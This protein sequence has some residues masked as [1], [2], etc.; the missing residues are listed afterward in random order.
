MTVRAVLF[1]LGDTLLYQARRPK[2]EDFHERVAE[3]VNPLL[4][5]WGVDERFD[6]KS[7]VRSLYQGIEATESEQHEPGYQ[8]DVPAIARRAL[9]EH[10]VEASPDQAKDLWSATYLG[11]EAWGY[12]LYPDTLDT[13]RRLRSMGIPTGLVSNTWSGSDVHL[14]DLVSLGISKSL[15]HV[16]VFSAD[17]R[18]AK[19][20][21]EP[22]RRALEG[23]AVQP[24]D[25]AFVGDN[26][27]ADI[28]GAKALGM[29]T[30]WKLNGRQDAPPAEEADHRI[31]ELREIFT[32]GVLP[33]TPARPA[34][35]SAAI[36]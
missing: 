11:F 13:L 27:K 23:L 15:M 18:R 29:T 33:E 12:E 31:H 5:S 24:D 36:D 10:G 16:F 14:P 30:I 3:R 9:A 21:P 6:A 34:G 32:I 22:F 35:G 2:E 7:M 8:V 25:A 20:H 4:R 1:D 17:V 19:P 26:L 28:R